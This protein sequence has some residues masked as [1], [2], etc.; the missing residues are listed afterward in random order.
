MAALFP[1][2]AGSVPFLSTFPS[3]KIMSAPPEHQLEPADSEKRM[4][5]VQIS[6]CNTSCS[7]GQRELGREFAPSF[8]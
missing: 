3:L 5:Q 8:D 4:F 1:G 6:V 7:Q 2:V